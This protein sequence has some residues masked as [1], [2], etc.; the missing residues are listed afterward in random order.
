[1][2]VITIDSLNICIFSFVSFSSVAV[3]LIP[4]GTPST[5]R[6]NESDHYYSGVARVLKSSLSPHNMSDSNRGSL[7]QVSNLT[8]NIENNN[9]LTGRGRCCPTGLGCG[10][11]SLNQGR[12]GEITRGS[13]TFGNNT[14]FTSCSRSAFNILGRSCKSSAPNDVDK[15]SVSGVNW[16]IGNANE[17]KSYS[18][19]ASVVP[20]SNHKN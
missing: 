3:M 14:K 20:G 5:P 7:S 10:S 17:L 1:M 8:L 19:C 16:T 11:N 15:F 4:R 12:S 18:E 9:M 2:K 6:S 13:W